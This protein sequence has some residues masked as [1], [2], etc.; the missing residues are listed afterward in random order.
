MNI[1]TSI[2]L[3]LFIID[4]TDASAIRR[5]NNEDNGNIGSCQKFVI[6]T[7]QRSGS[8]WACELLDLQSPITCGGGRSF[9]ASVR[10]SEPMTANHKTWESYENKMNESF[11]IVA[12]RQSCGT[13]TGRQAAGFKLM[14]NE[15]PSEF[16]KSGQLLEYFVKNDVA[17]IHLVRDAKVLRIASESTMEEERG[18]MKTPLP[19]TLDE[20]EAKLIAE[21]TP[22]FEW[23]EKTM[24]TIKFEEKRD[25]QWEMLVKY[26]PNTKYH[27]LTY[28]QLLTK[29]NLAS[30]VSQLLS[31][32]NLNQD[33]SEKSHPNLNSELQRL[34]KG[35]CSGRVAN[36]DQFRTAIEG[37]RTASACD[38]LDEIYDDDEEEEA[39]LG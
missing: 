11:G 33:D 35:T 32:L 6:L 36:Y 37:T 10:V 9:S 3:F 12:R 15:I 18:K 22:L 1:N 2:I 30:E 17:V 7:S 24:Y 27:K 20:S 8:T 5:R 16:R 34:H 23:D 28:E 31:F 39:A 13:S 21:S 19:H 14:Y 26:V 29:D 25:L 38:Y 4:L